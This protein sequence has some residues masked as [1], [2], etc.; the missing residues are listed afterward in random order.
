MR[1]FRWL[2]LLAVGVALLAVLVG[3]VAFALYPGTYS[4]RAIAISPTP[5][6]WSVEW[7][8]ELPE[9]PFAGST[10]R[11]F[12]QAILTEPRFVGTSPLHDPSY[13]LAV[14]G[15]DP[16]LELTSAAD[17]TPASVPDGAEW[18]LFALR[19]GH[20][21]IEISL[22]YRQSWCFPCDT[23][24]V[25]EYTTH[26]IT[27]KQLAGDVDCNAVV[28]SIDAVLVLQ[29]AAELLSE[30]PCE[31]VA[32]VNQDGSVNAVDALLILQF[33]VRPLDSLPP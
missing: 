28:N 8:V 6:P 23:H 19:A 27:V 3:F 17:V 14:T 5:A 25:I 18:E 33:V 2:R 16:A 32:D 12:A 22:T 21:T 24:T 13:S 31:D 11:V 15:S 7:N 9:Q 29:L 20:A 10:L 4:G 26:T 1:S 30:L